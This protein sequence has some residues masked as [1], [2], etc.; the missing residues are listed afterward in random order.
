MR[1]NGLAGIL[2][3]CT[4]ILFLC[5]IVSSA[6]ASTLYVPDDYT[7]IQAAVDAAGPRYVIV[8]RDG[9]YKENAKVNKPHL[10]IKSENGAD[11]TVVE[12]IFE[13]TEDHVD[14]TGFTVKTRYGK[15][16]HLNVV[17]HCN[18]QNNKIS[19]HHGIY[20]SDSSNNNI[21]NNNVS[22]NYYG[23]PLESSYSNSISDN[24]IA[25]NDGIGI[26]LW[27]F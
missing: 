16:I 21:I 5:A 18:I 12:G 8:V 20:L 2:L 27:K 14:I 9:T 26:L 13:L 6:S 1:R 15:A 3:I 25:N 24:T 4:M 7:T 11:K 22:N 19:A 17:H 23:I 10:S